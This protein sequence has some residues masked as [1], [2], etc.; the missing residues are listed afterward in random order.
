MF[1]IAATFLESWTSANLHD[2][3][4]R[5]VMTYAS[6]HN[7]RKQKS[8]FRRRQCLLLRTDI[9]QKTVAECYSSRN[10]LGGEKRGET[11]VFAVSP[12]PTDHVSSIAALSFERSDF[13]FKN[14][15]RYFVHFY[16]CSCKFAL[17]LCIMYHYY[18]IIIIIISWLVF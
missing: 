17:S 1:Q 16:C 14:P 5:E 9:L 13:F 8:A 2:T 12:W 6:L 15:L 7:S 10:V 11:A 4:C 18:H 3:I